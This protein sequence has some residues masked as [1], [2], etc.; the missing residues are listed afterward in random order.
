MLLKVGRKYKLVGTGSG[1]T[2]RIG[3]IVVITKISQDLICHNRIYYLGD[4]LSLTTSRFK[5]E[6]RPVK[7]PI[8]FKGLL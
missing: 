3:D 5:E 1:L 6:Y 7:N 4:N 2:P 8:S